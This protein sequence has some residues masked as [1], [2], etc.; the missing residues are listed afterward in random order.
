MEIGDIIVGK[1]H[2]E[3]LGDMEGLKCSIAELGLLQPIVVRKGTNELVAGYRRLKALVELGITSLVEGAQVNLVDIDSLVRGEHDENICRKDFT[4]SEKVAIF[5]AVKEE[6]L[7][8]N[9]QRQITGE[10]H[11]RKHG[12]TGGRSGID[13]AEEENGAG[14]GDKRRYG[15]ARSHAAKVVGLHENTLRKATEIVA[16]AKKEPRRYGHLV[17]EMD[18]T[19][20]VDPIFQKY[21]R[22]R[23]RPADGRHGL[24]QV[25]SHTLSDTQNP[26][27]EFLCNAMAYIPVDRQEDLARRFGAV[28]HLVKPGDLDRAVKSRS[29][30]RGLRDLSEDEIFHFLQDVLEQ[31]ETASREWVFMPQVRQIASVVMGVAENH[32]SA[33]TLDKLDFF[34]IGLAGFVDM[35]CNYLQVARKDGIIEELPLDVLEKYLAAIDAFQM[36]YESKLPRQVGTLR[37]KE[38]ELRPGEMPDTRTLRDHA[39]AMKANEMITDAAEGAVPYYRSQIANLIQ[40][41]RD[42]ARRLTL[43]RGA[44]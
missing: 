12:G 14:T 44:C 3:E 26:I 6:Q 42:G 24:C 27:P 7:R 40:S 10:T 39:N 32:G 23:S 25:L 21:V 9:T 36:L 30:D 13:G 35:T 4:I 22:E 15:R 17:R 18:L 8:I 2:R 16:A 31:A 11:D 41:L 29:R 34:M 38:C 33:T 19:G 37:M 1:R 5:E 28:L 20:K 43:T